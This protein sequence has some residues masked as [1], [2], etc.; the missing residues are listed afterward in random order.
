VVDI[1]LVVELDNDGER[2]K[3]LDL[4]VWAAEKVSSHCPGLGRALQMGQGRLY[5]RDDFWGV[6]P[7]QGE[8]ELDTGQ[9]EVSQFGS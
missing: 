2:A 5:P 1:P 6:W 4:V 7:I 3:E 9:L 8:D